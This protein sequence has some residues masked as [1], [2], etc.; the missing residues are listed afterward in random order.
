[1]KK[2]SSPENQLSDSNDSVDCPHP[3]P[4]I[5]ISDSS[6]SEEQKNPSL[7][8]ST[9]KTPHSKRKKGDESEDSSD[10]SYVEKTRK[11]TPPK[12]RLLPRSPAR[13]FLPRR[14]SSQKSLTNNPRWTVP[15]NHLWHRLKR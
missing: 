9:M 7:K 11:K 12:K 1:M 3:K 6:V 5:D 13:H 10:E 8:K 4:I 14:Q 2:H 15:M